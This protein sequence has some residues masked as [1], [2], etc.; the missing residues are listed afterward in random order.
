MTSLDLSSNDI[1][2]Y[3]KGGAFFPTPEGTFL[4]TLLSIPLISGYLSGPAAI[5][6][7]IKDMGA[8]TSLNLANNTLGTEDAGNALGAA[9]AVNTA[10]KQLDLSKNYFNEY[11]APK[12]AKEIA[13]GLRD[14][15]AIP[16]KV[17]GL[18]N[19]QHLN[20][21]TGRIRD[22]LPNGRRVVQL[23]NGEQKSLMPANLEIIATGLSTLDAR[24]NGIPPA[25]KALLQGACDAKGVYL[26]V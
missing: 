7:A 24:N 10:L 9:L 11:H 8:L 15:R 20:G 25:E 12:F 21:L 13:I 3:Y 14:N 17:Y 6:N 4:N 2:G 19:A 18:K 26:R 22:V 5:A 1:G 23:E 16:V